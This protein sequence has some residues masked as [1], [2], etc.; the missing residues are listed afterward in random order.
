MVGLE[1]RMKYLRRPFKRT[2]VE[3]AGTPTPKRLPKPLMPQVSPMASHA[4][5]EDDASHT[6]NV[7]MLQALS[8]QVHTMH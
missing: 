3:D 2:R 5:G 6:R 8:K 7:K 4:I 1:E